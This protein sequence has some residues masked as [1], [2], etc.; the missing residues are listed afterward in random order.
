[1]S[2][3]L[4]AARVVTS[5]EVHSPG[6]V[7]IECGAITGV[8]AGSPTEASPAEASSAGSA[9][10]SVSDSARGAVVLT[11]LGGATIVPGFVDAHSHGGGGHGYPDGTAEAALAAAEAHLAHGTTSTMASLVSAPPGM[12][13]EQVS[14]LAPL[15]GSGELRGIHLE[16]P[17]LAPERKGAHD[18]AALREPDPREIA[19]LL[20]AGDGAIRMATIAPEVPGAF[21]AIEQLREAGVVVAIGH[22][23]ADY[24]TARRAIDAGASVATH[25]FNAM[26]PLLHRRPGPALALLQDERVTLELVADGVHLHPSLVEWVLRSAGPERVMLVTDAMQA[27]GC[28]D[29]SYRLGALDVEV[30]RGAATLAGTDT[31]AGGTA[32]MDRLFRRAVGA[33]RGAGA[34]AERADGVSDESLIAAVRVTATTPARA[35]GWCDAGDIR[36]GASADLVVLDDRLRVER[37]YRFGVPRPAR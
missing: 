35:M 17:W 33:W 14:A 3:V 18:P 1:M 4:L 26:P 36:I 37:V 11:D 28:G 20:A 22:T 6:W 9:S 12:L 5:S 27:A 31:I 15:V 13:L 24:E 16:G 29:G 32:T 2:E 21:A 7:R 8:G 25:L 10:A 23:E 30:S 19:E 34:D